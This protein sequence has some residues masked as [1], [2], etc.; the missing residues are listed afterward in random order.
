MKTINLKTMRINYKFKDLIANN[1]DLNPD[2][3]K[4]ISVQ[5]CIRGRN[6]KRY[7]YTEEDVE[8]IK[9]M[10]VHDYVDIMID[11]LNLWD[12]IEEPVMSDEIT[13]TVEI[14]KEQLL[15]TC[16]IA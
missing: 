16:K 9:K 11:Q 5:P 13:F 1:L 3:V 4:G 14:Y 12:Y 8:S 6:Y 10:R 7:D 2:D 15:V